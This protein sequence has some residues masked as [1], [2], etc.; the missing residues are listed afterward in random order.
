MF[1]HCF[2]KL[3]LPYLKK[4]EVIHS[5]PVQASS[6]LVPM[7]LKPL[8]ACHKPV[9]CLLLLEACSRPVNHSRSVTGLLHVPLMNK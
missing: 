6:R 9:I 4:K 5:V 2:G 3:Q 8:H 7:L 1:I